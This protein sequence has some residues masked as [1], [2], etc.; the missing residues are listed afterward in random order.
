MLCATTTEPPRILIHQCFILKL[1]LKILNTHL[2]QKILDCRD[3]TITHILFS[4]KRA[5][6]RLTE[7]IFHI[8]MQ[9]IKSS[10]LAILSQ[11]AK[12]G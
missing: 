4:L 6:V 2:D 7:T 12:A 3:P 9:P 8:I 11:P 5:I 10:K 1:R